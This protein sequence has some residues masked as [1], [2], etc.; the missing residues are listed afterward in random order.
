[1][2]T[3][4]NAARPPLPVF[5][6]TFIALLHACGYFVLA[7]IF[8]IDAVRVSA[9]RLPAALM[10]GAAGLMAVILAA[11]GMWLYRKKA[12]A[13]APLLVLFIVET[14]AYLVTIG[15]YPWYVSAVGMLAIWGIWCTLHPRTREFLGV[16]DRPQLFDEES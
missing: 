16:H 14:M 8:T 12:P 4:S 13:R 9:Y 6:A 11:L 10:A 1:M 2:N 3:K 15:S 5:L 7:I